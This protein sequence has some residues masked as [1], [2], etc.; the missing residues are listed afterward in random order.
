MNANIIDAFNTLEQAMNDDIK[1]KDRAT[2]QAGMTL[3]AFMLGTLERQATALE[4]IAKAH[5][6]FVERVTVGGTTDAP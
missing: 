2:A 3:F 1:P 6:N 4:S 5:N